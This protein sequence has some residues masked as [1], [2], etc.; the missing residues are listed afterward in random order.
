MPPGKTK[1]E[2]LAAI[3]KVIG[4]LAE[5]FAFGHF[6]VD[7][8]KQE[9][10]VFALLALGREK[11]DLARP[12]ENFLY[13]HVKNRFINLKRNKFRRTDAPCKA[14]HTGNPCGG[15]N[16]FCPPYAAWLKRNEAKAC[17]SR[18]LDITRVSGDREGSVRVTD[19]GQAAVETDEL[20]A[21]IRQ[22]LPVELQGA[23]LKLREGAPVPKP[24]RDAVQAAVREILD[25]PV[26]DETL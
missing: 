2:V 26:V 7:D 13:R 21:R 20:V 1:A 8:I 17:L 4:I 16:Q 11:Y 19:A 9:G 10:R 25:G 23:F 14:C 15:P 22:R 6:D 12:L 18:R 5:S 3:E 24:Q